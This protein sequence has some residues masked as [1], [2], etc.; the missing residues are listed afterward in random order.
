MN[1]RE[2]TMEYERLVV[3]ILHHS[4]KI[5]EFR[6]RLTLGIGTLKII[7]SNGVFVRGFFSLKLLRGEAT[8]KTKRT[9]TENSGRFDKIVYLDD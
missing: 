2:V 3:L 7:A 1:L 9:P 4:A 8:N 5:W 6:Y